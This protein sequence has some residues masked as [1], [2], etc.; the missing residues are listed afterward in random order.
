MI[1]RAL[2]SRTIWL[3]LIALAVAVLNYALDH[4]LWG[5][6]ADAFIIPVLAILNG[7]LR[8]DTVTPVGVSLPREDIQNMKSQP[9]AMLADKI[10]AAL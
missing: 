5:V 9:A 1:T 10:K 6:E 4:Q 8:M 3:N 2:K 7:A